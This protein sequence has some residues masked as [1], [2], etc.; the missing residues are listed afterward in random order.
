MAR[1][2]I[3]ITCPKGHFT[4][5]AHLWEPAKDKDIDKQAERSMMPTTCSECGSVIVT[6]PHIEG[7]DR[8]SERLARIGGQ[9]VRSPLQSRPKTKP[10]E[11]PLTPLQWKQRAFDLQRERPGGPAL[12]AVTGESL[13]WAVDEVHHPLEKR[14]LR[15]RSLHHL[16]WDERNSMAVKKRIHDGHT[17]KLRPIARRFVPSRAFQFAHSVGPWAL[18]RVNEDHP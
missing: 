12:C 9:N 10:K 8:E 6:L 7:R 5:F 13:S 16:V 18:Q 1:V 11:G 15:A 17:S 4:A 3:G 14:L 2:A